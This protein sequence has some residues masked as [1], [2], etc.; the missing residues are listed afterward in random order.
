[1]KEMIKRKDGSYSQ[2]GLWDNIRANR[3]SGKTPTKEMLEQ[4]RKIRA[5]AAYGMEV[6]DMNIGGY[7]PR[8]MQDGG[9]PDGPMALSQMAAVI[10]KLS[11]L[12]E[13]I[14]EDSDLEP[15]ISSKLAVMDH[16]A[17]AV[18]DYMMYGQDG[19]DDIEE[20]EVELSEQEMEE[21]KNGG[22]PER[23]RA[24]G[25]TKV[26]V[27]RKST[28]PGKKWMV[29]AK[30]GNQYK[31]V[32]GG[33]KGMQ[34][35][36]QHR[37]K[38]RQKKFWSR[39]GGKS[40]SKATD[41]FSPLYW[42]KRFG[43]WE[44]GGSVE[45]QH[46][47]YIGMDGEWHKAVGSGTF[48]GNAY[49]QVGGSNNESA[50]EI[51]RN[52]ALGKTAAQYAQR[53]VK[54]M[55]RDKRNLESGTIVD[56]G[57]NTLYVIDKGKI[58]SSKPVLTGQAGRSK[59]KDPNRNPYSVV[60]LEDNP[61]NRSTPTGTYFMNP[62]QNI[63]G[64]PGFMLKPIEAYNIPAP[65]ARNTAIHVTYGAAPKPGMIGHADPQEFARR[66]AAYG[67]PS[68]SRYM[69][70][71]C[72]NMQ[73]EAIDC[74]TGQF[75]K[76]DTA[77]YIDSR[78]PRDMEYIKKVKRKKSGGSATVDS[79]ANYIANNL[80]PT[81]MNP[82][83]NFI[84]RAQMG[85][86][87]QSQDGQ[88]MQLVSAYAQ[89]QGVDPQQIM[90]QL[91]QMTAPEQEQAI[92]QMVDAVQNQSEQAT[93]FSQPIMRGGGNM[94]CY[95]CGGMYAYG[96]EMGGPVD[97]PAMPIDVYGLPNYGGGGAM[98]GYVNNPYVEDMMEMQDGGKPEWLIRAQLKAQGYAGNVL[99]QKMKQMKQGGIN[100]NPANK[101]KFTAKANA[102]G[103]GVQAFASKVLGAP[104]GKYS[105]ATR[106]QANFA[107]NASKWKHQLGG[108][109]VGQTLE[110]VDQDTLDELTR[111]GYEFQILG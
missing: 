10:D 66:N 59:S 48:S 55:M 89:M 4:E 76:G 18:S 61:Q 65:E 78:N 12:R 45:M 42:H 27:K 9:E 36:T 53:D 26:G 2:R 97:L 81:N 29:L 80:N 67:K 54:E 6:P 57:T 1:M 16:Y 83:Y 77:I 21:M 33:Y 93:Q 56:K 71:G 30:K 25:F 60:D 96:G 17:D 88:M 7:F 82:L 94:P 64:Y 40:S 35:F 109:T 84:Q 15:W 85:G 52:T 98:R 22:I 24:K 23:Y 20:E 28:R 37:N 43:T 75:P 101:G 99:E 11:K 31:I 92:Q 68:S 79:T 63:Y 51:L 47:G 86:V 19:E 108:L 50:A 87:Q 62:A 69:S 74:L 49:Y 38:N 72:T 100:I 73:G 105:P 111:L 8:F 110:D 58:V 13:F 106:K 5:K 70:F 32:H 90:A 3:G 102:A 104:E 95:E 103:M 46:G 107:R 39:M 34:D 91:Q 44:E 41:P 14:N